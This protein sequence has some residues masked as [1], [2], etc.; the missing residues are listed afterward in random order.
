MAPKRILLSLITAVFLVAAVTS[1]SLGE[2][3]AKSYPVGEVTIRTERV[4]LGI[5]YTWGHGTLRYKGKEY[6][7]KVK[8]LNLIG[9]GFTTLRAK[10]EVYN[11]K[12]LSEFPGTYYGV[13]GGATL[14]KESAGLV[15]KNSKGVLLNLKT[16]QKGASLRLGDQGL[17]ISPEWQ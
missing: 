1:F 13:E 6:K 7:F 4:S 14:I 8:G 15:I 2:K 11:M 3:E 16:E 5:G 17:N 10:G 9:L 12:S